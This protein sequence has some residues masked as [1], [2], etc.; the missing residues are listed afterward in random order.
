MIQKW[1]RKWSQNVIE[2][3]R[4]WSKVSN[5]PKIQEIYEN[6]ICFSEISS[7]II[8]KPL[9]KTVEKLLK[10]VLSPLKIFK[11]P[12][13]QYVHCNC[14]WQFDRLF[15]CQSPFWFWSQYG[16]V[17]FRL[18]RPAE[19][20]PT[21]PTVHQAFFLQHLRNELSSSHN[22]GIQTKK[23]RTFHTPIPA[24]FSHKLPY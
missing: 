16:H 22:C 18:C 21:L 24:K 15:S 7:K 19:Y 4:K 17:W 9:K 1:N 3:S 6:D 5:W 20:P 8:K 13:V 12:Y 23:W 11:N 14:Q 2:I 10:S